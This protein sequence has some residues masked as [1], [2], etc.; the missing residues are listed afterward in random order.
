[1]YPAVA[2]FIAK[3][4]Q[5]DMSILPTA[6]NAD[7]S[8]RA[9][10]LRR[11][12]TR[13]MLARQFLLRRGLRP[14]CI[15]VPRVRAMRHQ[16]R[17]RHLIARTF[18]G[19][20]M[21]VVL[22]EEVSVS[23]WRFGFFE[24]SLSGFLLRTLRPGQTVL[25]VG[26]HIGYISL[27]AARAVGPAGAVHAFEPTPATFAVLSRNLD[28]V[29]H[30]IAAAL[31]V[32][33]KPGVIEINDHGWCYCAYNSAFGSRLPESVTRRAPTTAIQVPAVRLDDYTRERDL[34][35][36]LVKIDAESSEFQVLQGMRGMLEN[37]RPLIIME[38]GDLGVSD[39][40][41][42]REL[43]E[44][45][46]SFGYIVREIHPVSF[47]LAPHQLRSSYEYDNLVFV[48]ADTS[49]N[50][51][52]GSL[53]AKSP[54]CRATVCPAAPHVVRLSRL[55]HTIRSLRRFLRRRA[56]CHRE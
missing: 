30:S 23:I 44:H 6:E 34:R 22:P 11:L 8:E 49:A 45:I 21:Q 28:P 29:P 38:V 52:K 36:D 24:A 16:G 9:A 31:A 27:L 35:P 42:S 39:V 33:D 56:R 2:N 55:R 47:A 4:R 26:A 14:A 12:R 41:S 7:L 25:D 50:S 10:L 1:M 18:W 3:G 13:Q 15:R 40:G 17:T 43:I 51:K 48:P 32:W 53:R 19:Q 37:E 46:V 54:A 20:P 5:N